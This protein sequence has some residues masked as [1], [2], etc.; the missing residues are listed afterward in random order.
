MIISEKEKLA[1]VGE[2]YNRLQDIFYIAGESKINDLVERWLPNISPSNSEDEVTINW[3]LKMC[4]GDFLQV[5]GRERRR[6]NNN[7]GT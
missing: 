6:G 5:I 3:T 4:V 2:I 1:I 7:A